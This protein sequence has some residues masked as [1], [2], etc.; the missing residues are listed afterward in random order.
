MHVAAGPVRDRSTR[1]GG[2]GACRRLS[3]GR[4]QDSQSSRRRLLLQKFVSL[5]VRRAHR[6]LESEAFGFGAA[7]AWW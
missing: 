3:F 5:L 4:R 6:L 2:L 7:W 1:A